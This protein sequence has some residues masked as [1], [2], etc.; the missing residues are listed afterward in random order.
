VF[1]ELKTM[2]AGVDSKIAC[3]VALSR[4]KCHDP[5]PKKKMREQADRNLAIYGYASNH[6]VTRGKKIMEAFMKPDEWAKPGKYPRLVFNLGVEASLQGGFLLEI[7]KSCMCGV[8]IHFMG[9]RIRIIKK[10]TYDE[11]LYCFDQMINLTDR[12]FY[13]IFSDDACCAYW[14]D[15]RIHFCNIDISGCDASH[16]KGIFDFLRGFFEPRAQEFFNP[17]LDQCQFTVVVRSVMDRNEKKHLELARPI[18]PS[19]STLTTFI[20]NIGSLGIAIAFVESDFDPK[21]SEDAGYITTFDDFEDWYRLQFLKH[22]PVYDINGVLRALANLGIPIRAS[23]MCR[24]DLPGRGPLLPRAR[25]FQANLLHGM[26]PRATVPLIEHMLKNAGGRPSTPPNT[27]EYLTF[28]TSPVFTITD[29][30]WAQRYDITSAEL[31]ELY[32]HLRPMS[33]SVD[34]ISCAATQKILHLDY[35]L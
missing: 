7:A 2:L 18:M 17:L 5:H 28:V 3:M 9:G 4:E 33:D 30:E 16:G 23:G 21:A 10:V 13:C 29:I 35:G 15:G 20:N 22:S 31:E 26:Y 14:K 19:G 24:G 32:H 1:E 12:Y 6:W 27:D 11:I 25:H 34:C 8:D